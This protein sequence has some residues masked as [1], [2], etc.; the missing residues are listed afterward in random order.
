[1][2]R[3]LLTPRLL[4]A[5]VV[6]SALNA[7]ST[8]HD[9]IASNEK[10]KLRRAIIAI[11]SVVAGGSYQNAFNYAREESIDPC[12]QYLLSAFVA[13][14]K[15]NYKDTDLKAVQ[16]LFDVSACENFTK[17]LLNQSPANCEKACSHKECEK[18]G[19]LFC[20][21]DPVCDE[22]SAARALPADELRLYKT[23]TDN[24]AC[25][26]ALAKIRQQSRNFNDDPHK[27]VSRR[28]DMIGRALLG[29]A[30]PPI[31]AGTLLFGLS[32]GPQSCYGSEPT[33]SDGKAP[34]CV[35]PD[36]YKIG[37]PI[38]WGIGLGLG[39]AGTVYQVKK[40]TEKAKIGAPTPADSMRAT[41]PAPLPPSWSPA[42]GGAL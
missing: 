5:A 4:L 28:N 37:A 30:V 25:D 38:L 12:L 11:T 23:L 31:V 35:Y 6:C 26:K 39:I 22:C 16:E 24:G 27:I 15:D 32:Y 36:N 19:F 2:I 13:G 8:V 7:L 21:K 42:A 40:Q 33:N 34:S 1:M 9:A 29:A 20:S 17:I 14:K 10:Q 3:Q 18:R 41:C